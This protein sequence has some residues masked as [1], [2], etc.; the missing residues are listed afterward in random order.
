MADDGGLPVILYN[1][2]GRTGVDLKPATV[3]A[4]ADH[5]QI[6]GVK[7]AVAAPERMT[8]LLGLRRPGFVVLSGDD[9]TA[10]RALKA[11]A[12]GVI[13]VIA[14]VVPRLWAELCALGRG[15]GVQAAESIDAMLAPLNAAAG[16]EPNPIPVKAALAM[17]GRMHDVLRLPLLPLS[18]ALRPQLQLALAQAEV[19][20]GASVAS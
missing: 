19:P 5:P 16:S 6:I 3:A 1:V 7:E 20:T 9:P 2:P 4:L 17:M 11:G 13:S 10:L 12:D 15:T 18:S 8:E 14:N